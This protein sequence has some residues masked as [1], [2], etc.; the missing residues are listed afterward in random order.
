M[1]SAPGASDS[2]Q[3]A[4][5]KSSAWRAPTADVIVAAVRRERPRSSGVLDGTGAPDV[6]SMLDGDYGSSK[7]LV[8]REAKRVAIAGEVRFRVR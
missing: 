7:Q 3:N 6:A 4:R 5:R 1:A 2:N 8:R